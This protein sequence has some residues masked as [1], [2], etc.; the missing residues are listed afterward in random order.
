[1]RAPQSAQA[2]APEARTILDYGV[3]AVDGAFA[4]NPAAR[5]A[6]GEEIVRA[7]R[8]FE[9]RLEDPVAHVDQAQ[10]RGQLMLT[11]IGRLRLGSVTEDFEFVSALDSRSAAQ[12]KRG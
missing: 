1:M 10:D 8:A 4:E 11:L 2:R 5:V 3:V 6:L 7:V 12:L 9:P